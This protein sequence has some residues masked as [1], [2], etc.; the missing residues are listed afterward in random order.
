MRK[1]LGRDRVLRD[2]PMEQHCSFRVGGPA[3][4]FLRVGTADELTDVQ[5][6]LAA[7]GEPYFVLGRGTNLLVGDHGY[8]GAVIT[9]T[10]K[11]ARP[12][13][14]TT[15]EN[16]SNEDQASSLHEVR[17]TG[18]T[19]TAG[20]GASLTSVARA[21]RD[22]GLQGLEFAAGIP[23]SVGG[24]LVMNAGAY[25]GEMKDVVQ[26]AL[27][28]LPDGTRQ[29]LSN[30]QL[31]F[32]Y[33]HSI[34]KEREGVVLE[35]VFR[36]KKGDPAAITAL[37]EDLSERRRQKQPLEYPSAG[38]TFKRPRGYYAGKLIE[39]A[40]L[41]GYTVGGACVSQKHC[42]FVINRD[43]ATAA[44]IRELIEDVQLRVYETAGVKLEREVIYLGEF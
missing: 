24:G 29:R 39:E 23:G 27:L 16:D 33:R 2:E 36:L 1:L 12:V 41:R 32:G 11:A 4:L 20:G 31:H 44:Q 15:E 14:D 19:V 13:T 5:K 30:E 42:G 18:E 8:R 26:D 10:G 3:D 17:V 22:H 35:V 21:A 7:A 37:M 9:L 40:G 34:L 43:H 38:S 6:M 28:L 25:G